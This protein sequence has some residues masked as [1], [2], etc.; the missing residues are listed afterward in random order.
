MNRTNE[1]TER[2]APAVSGW[3]RGLADLGCTFMELIPDTKRTRG[4][5]A[6]FDTCVGQKGL[7]IAFAW[8][9][10]GAGLGFRP[11]PPL[12]V[13]DVDSHDEVE[14]IVS[15]LLDARIV[16]L[17]VQTP[18]G[19][20]HFYFCLPDGFRLEGLKNH[21][22]HPRDADGNTMS[23]DF[24]FGP[25]TLLVAPGTRR[26]GKRYEPAS[27]WRTPP[28]VDPRMF[29]PEGE[30]WSDSRPFIISDRPLKDRVARACA[31][32][33]GPA[34][35]SISGKGGRKTLAGVCAHLVRYLNLDP[36]LAR[37]LLTHGKDPWN[38]RC[39]S[40]NGDRYPWSD[41]ELR[42][43]CEEAVNA[44]PA[45]GVKALIREQANRDQR[46][47]RHAFIRILR[48]SLK[49]SNSR[50]VTLRRVHRL[51]VWFGLERLNPVLLGRELAN[52][53]IPRVKATARRIITIPG[54]DYRSLVSSLLE[55]K[56]IRL[57]ER[58]GKEG[59]ALMK[60]ESSLPVRSRP[61]NPLA[62]PNEKHT[63]KSF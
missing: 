17:R 32:L 43:A 5:W 11:A 27:D 15:L 37:N 48:S 39:R 40:A 56:R 36:E 44:V 30:F 60:R 63:D 53:G 61:R 23:V 47:Q 59:C 16:P 52:H 26:N 25:R 55:S 46:D 8:L 20:A 10:R 50:R 13:L 49:V 19:G 33:R 4:S 6:R 12:W 58:L 1:L 31:Y 41:S 45:A 2:G 9:G 24:K 62:T 54:L 7:R 42:A 3:L 22:C 38:Q 35:V 34:P 21:L 51:F 29:L 14:R 57:V 28:T 18:S